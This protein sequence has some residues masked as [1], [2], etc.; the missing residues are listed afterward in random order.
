VYEEYRN[1]RIPMPR[2]AIL[3]YALAQADWTEV[4]P[5]EL[6]VHDRYAAESEG[7]A[8]GSSARRRSP[9]H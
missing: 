9:L 2:Y 1:R 3:L 5:E 8:G 6:E 4:P 7:L